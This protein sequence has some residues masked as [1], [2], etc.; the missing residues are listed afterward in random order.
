MEV[1]VKV[2]YNR[3][4]FLYK[5]YKVNLS[6]TYRFIIDQA[7][8]GGRAD[9]AV[10]ALCED[11]SRARVQG[12]IEQGAVTING[13]ALK[14]SR[15]LEVGDVVEIEIPP[16]VPCEPEAE[17][18][19][20]DIVF[21]DEHMLV[22]N[23][24]AGMVVHPGAGNWSGT[25]VN[26][27]LHHCGED[28]SGI[29]GVVR[30]G[31]VHRLDKDTTGLMVVA[32][33]DKAHKGLSEQ[34]SDR[35]LSRIYKALVL[36]VPTLLKGKVNKPIGRHQSHRLKMA[37]DEKNGREAMTHYKVEKAYGEACALVECKLETGRTHQIRVHMGFL[38]HPLIGDVLYGPQPTAL[39]A[40]LKKEGYEQNVVENLLSFPRQALHAASISFIHPVSGVEMG[41]EAPIPDD[42]INLLKSLEK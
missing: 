23:K 4:A 12:L 8:A 37:I 30:P 29:G 19:P 40:A 1:K 16:A 5:A 27:L 13:A 11:L 7:H 10:S 36:K 38:K 34:L 32:K 42:F 26:A 21:E 15:R 6:E 20:L 31:I 2:L 14:A 25:L 33:N 3:D 24:A 22:I 17:D 35:S 28:L 9:K 41:F 18:I 39:Q